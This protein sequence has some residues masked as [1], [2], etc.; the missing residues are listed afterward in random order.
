[1]CVC[2]CVHRY[3]C[4]G[5][6][7]EKRCCESLSS[8]SQNVFLITDWCLRGN[9]KEHHIWSHL[10]KNMF[11]LRI[12]LLMNYLKCRRQ[13]E[14]QRT[15]D[16]QLWGTEASVTLR[17]KNQQFCEFHTES[18]FM[19]DTGFS[20]HTHTPTQASA[21]THTP[22]QASKAKFYIFIFSGKILIQ[23]LILKDMQ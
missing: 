16:V 15:A 9:L 10:H 1:V 19:S 3:I 22:T 18:P 5:K 23:H 14:K 21:H 8:V 4:E 20:S 13:T 17:L 7:E 11:F 6:E 12:K 2:V